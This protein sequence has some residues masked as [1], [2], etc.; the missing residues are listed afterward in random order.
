MKFVSFNALVLGCAVFS[1][2]VLADE[3]LEFTKKKNLR[4]WSE[5]NLPTDAAAANLSS[6]IKFVPDVFNDTD[7][8]PIPED[9]SVDEVSRSKSSSTKSACCLSY[10]RGKSISIFDKEGFHD[11]NWVYRFRANS[12]SIERDT[13]QYKCTNSYV[14]LKRYRSDGSID[15][16]SLGK[17]GGSILKWSTSSSSWDHLDTVVYSRSYNAC[18]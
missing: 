8:I 18:G 13:Y 12:G 16:Y 7:Q 6:D 9:E 15:Y 17:V 1:S 5:K 3:E 10:V 4:S 2:S 14:F 11:T